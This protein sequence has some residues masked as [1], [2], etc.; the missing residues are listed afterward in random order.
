LAFSAAAA[1]AAAESGGGAADAC[2]DS[3]VVGDAAAAAAAAA[4]SVDGEAGSIEKRFLQSLHQQKHLDQ[5]DLV[6][7]AGVSATASNAAAVG[8]Y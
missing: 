4:D 7:A 1:A 6:A 5:Y 8:M 3:V 2:V